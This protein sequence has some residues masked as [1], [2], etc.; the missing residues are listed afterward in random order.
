MLTDVVGSCKK[1]ADLSGLS[2]ETIYQWRAEVKKSQF[3]SLAV[4]ERPSAA[5]TVT[6]T[7]SVPSQLKIS[8]TVTVTT[9]KGFSIGGLDL[10]TALILLQKL[11]S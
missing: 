11:E 1:A 9:P 7:N 5:V 8:G 2:V 3:K 6:A 4:V 10:E